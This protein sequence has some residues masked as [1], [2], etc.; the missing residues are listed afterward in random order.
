MVALSRVRS[1]QDLVLW[2]FHPS[3]IFLHPFYHQ[4]LLW[5]DCV[6]VI[7]PT[8]PTEMVDHPERDD[9]V[10][11]NAPIPEPPISNDQ[12]EVQTVQLTDDPPPDQASTALP[13][14]RGHGRPRKTDVP[15]A[16]AQPSPITAKRG[17]GRPRKEKLP[18]TRTPP[19]P[20]PPE[21]N[22]KRRQGRPR[23]QAPPPQAADLKC[24]P[25]ARAQP[26]K[27][28]ASKAQPGTPTQ[29]KSATPFVLVSPPNT[30]RKRENDSSETP[31][32]KVTKV[33]TPARPHT[34]AG[35]PNRVYAALH[36]TVFSCL[37]NRSPHSVLTSMSSVRDIIDAFNS[38]SAGL[39][40][41]VE[42]VNALPPLYADD[43]PQLPLASSIA[44]LCHPLFLQT[45]KP[46]VT[47]ADGDC[48][49]HA[50]S[51]VV[52]GSEQLSLTFRVL[53]AYATVKYMNVMA[54][55]LRDAFP[56]LSHAQCVQKCN[57]L[58]LQALR[59]G[60]WG[61]DQHLFLLSLLLNRPI[62]IFNTFY[63]TDN[64]VQLILCA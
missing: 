31:Q 41:I 22:T 7:R 5:C 27:D 19:Q 11:C 54:N 1:L 2:Q 15:P 28:C 35:A 16:S 52:C 8:P 46:V 10:K 44:S 50:L 39:D 21:S 56:L 17:R 37:S 13:A 30:T 48:M 63:I 42:S 3:A 64:G 49:Y 20:H 45:Y 34:N 25:T 43:S 33:N 12:R 53:M 4:L 62:F 57:T 51:R 18:A 40:L 32:C 26:T 59:V 9:N 29:Q 24:T 55:S 58:L 23:K 61:C 6:D 47:T 38:I 60:T 36:A 14:K